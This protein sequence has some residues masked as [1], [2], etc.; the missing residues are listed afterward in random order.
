MKWS[1]AIVQWIRT[2]ISHRSRRPER[3]NLYPH[4]G[5]QAYPLELLGAEAPTGYSP[6]CLYLDDALMQNSISLLPACTVGFAEK[7]WLKVLFTDLL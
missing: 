2:E 7:S 1:S 4:H 6:P 5:K 3:L